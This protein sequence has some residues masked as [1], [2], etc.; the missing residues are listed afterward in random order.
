MHVLHADGAGIGVAQRPEDV[1]QLHRLRPGQAA[2]G[3]RPLEVPDGESVVGGVDLHRAGGALSPQRIEVGDQVAPHPVDVDELQDPG[4]LVDLVLGVVL[5]TAVDPPPHRLVGDVEAPE[6]L[7]VEL[8]VAEKQLVDVTEELARLR[9]L[10]DPVVVGRRQRDDVADAEPGDRAGIGA[11][12]LGRVVDGADADDGALAGH[13]PGDGVDGADRPRVRECERGAGEIVGT[14][15][16]DAHPADDVLVGGEEGVEVEGV[17]FFDVGH[18][19]AVRA[20]G[21]GDIDGQTEVHVFV[22]DHAGLAVDGGVAGVHTRHA[23]QRP[24]DGPADEVGEADLAAPL[25]PGQVVVDHPPVHL[26]QPRRNHPGGCRGGHAETGFH[27][28]DDQGAGAAE[29]HRLDIRFCFWRLRRPGRGAARGGSRRRCRGDTPHPPG[30]VLL[31]SVGPLPHARPWLRCTLGGSRS[32][33]RSGSRWRRRRGDRLA[34]PAPFG[35]QPRC[36]VGEEVPPALGHRARVLQPLPVDLLDQADV[37]AEVAFEPAD[38]R[39]VVCSHGLSSS[40]ARPPGRR[41]RATGGRSGGDRTSSRSG[42]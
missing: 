33:S 6:D 1:G 13:Q 28:S 26:E 32:R 21:L 3:E 31:R 20:V 11:L 17:G 19:Q 15:L 7:V 22:A 4:L 2:G 30:P 9:P 42:S 38:R 40:T 10:D 24:D 37:G 36:V 23:A 41:G 16:A 12:V 25:H 27:V 8:V 29:R 39:D 14:D 18:Q 5:G 34:V 35:G